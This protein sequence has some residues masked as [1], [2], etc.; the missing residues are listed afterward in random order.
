MKISFHGPESVTPIAR[1]GI[2]CAMVGT[3]LIAP[4]A[5]AAPRQPVRSL[6][7]YRHEYVI[8]QK[9][10]LSCGAAALATLLNFQHGE[11]LTERDVA[12]G[13]M[14]R[15]TYRDNPGLIQQREGFSLLDLKRYVLTLGYE[16]IGYGNLSWD[17]LLR[18]APMMVPVNLHGYNHFVIVRGTAGNRAM[19]SDPAWGNRTMPVSDFMQAWIDYPQIGRVG[20]VIQ[21]RADRQSQRPAINHLVPRASDFAML[22]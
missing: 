10:D 15:D 22:K 8:T 11:N 3:L 2:L 12:I 5:F 4:L 18:Q 14:R 21:R 6:L 9:F 1:H 17:D 16:G 13:L 19:L 7:E 20:F